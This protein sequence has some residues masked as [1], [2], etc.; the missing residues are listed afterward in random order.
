MKVFVSV[1]LLCLGGALAS[2]TP[3]ADSSLASEVGLQAR[4]AQLLSIAEGARQLQLLF[5][6]VYGRGSETARALST[7]I[8]PSS[9]AHALRENDPVEL[10]LNSIELDTSV[11]RQRLVCEL[12]TGISGYRFGGMAY[13]LIKSGVPALERYGY[14]STRDLGVDSCRQAFPCQFSASPLMERAR[15][16]RSVATDFCDLEGDSYTSSACR[17]IASA[18]DT[19]ETL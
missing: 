16:V 17:L 1:A 8:T 12:Q 15:Q 18:V 14:V 11:C 13:E 6:E 2:P 10:A 4:E 19:L 5:S 7:S 9:V 3:Y